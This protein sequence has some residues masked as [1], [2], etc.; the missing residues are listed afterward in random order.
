MSVSGGEEA[1]PV[2]PV[3]DPTHPRAHSASEADEASQDGHDSVDL[4]PTEDERRET[5]GR[6]P[7]ALRTFLYI[8]L[9]ADR[10][11]AGGARFA[12]DGV[13][14]VT[15]VRA[16]E[17]R[18]KRESRQGLEQLVLSL[19][20]RAVSTIHA[21]IRHE[22]GGWVLEDAGSTNGSY[23]NGARVERA[24]LGPGDIV[25]L[26][27]TFLW[28][29][30][31]ALPA[32]E[33]AH[34]LE[35]HELSGRP[36]A[37]S[38]LLPELA[39]AITR[40][41]RIALSSITVTLAGESGTGKELLAQAIH[42]ASGRTGPFVAVNCGALTATLAESQLFGHLRGAF[43]G[44][45]AEAIGFIRSADQGTLLLDE[46]KDLT[47]SAQAALL[48]VLQEREVIPVGA[49]RPQKVDVRFIAT[50][51]HPLTPA[52]QR[53]VFRED[54][55]ARL[56]GFCYLTPPLRERREDIGLILARLLTKLGVVE[57]DAPRI[58]PE[59]ALELL[60]YD[61][62]LN[63]RELEQWLARSWALT[64]AGRLD[65]EPPCALT[66]ASPAGAAEEPVLSSEDAALRQRLI[67]ELRAARGNVAQVARALGKAPMQVH[68]WMRRL[69]VTPRTFRAPLG[70]PRE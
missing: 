7:R 46:A 69:A 13:D 25:E 19:P 48:R 38:T 3:A 68:R 43:S 14:A 2:G 22:P 18:V 53:G 24:L 8:V 54:L 30:S 11:L 52:V 9:E 17:R 39:V 35:S 67:D 59:L 27:R 32:D 21:R 51:P 63:V 45:N 41:E 58:A 23:V 40:L 61:W 37:F 66:S 57:S 60:G 12:L 55:Y 33:S 62:P 42:A 16:A 20:G 26:G 5:S 4:E 64:D 65:L 36:S 6:V 1:N 10:P 28:I 50:S 49:A 56:S 44:A 47:P 29:R 70:M 15:V 34:D 31:A